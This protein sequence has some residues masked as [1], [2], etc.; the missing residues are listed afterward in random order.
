MKSIIHVLIIAVFLIPSLAIS[1]GNPKDPV[2]AKA[3]NVQ[4]TQYELNREINKVLPFSVNFHGG[5]SEEKKQEIH[6][7]ALNTVI[8]RALK[9]QYALDNEISAPSSLVEK[10]VSE[11]ASK[12]RSP[13]E[14][15]AGL[16]GEG[17]SGFRASV[18]RELLAK[19]AENIVVE[20]KIQVSEEDV[21]NYF[22]E[23]KH[24]YVRPRQYQASHILV[25]V[26]PSSNKEE[27]AELKKKAQDLLARAKSGE[28]F[29]NLAYYNSDDRSKYVGGDLGL[30]HEGQT[31]SEFDAALK[32]MEVGEISDLVKTMYGYHIIKM[33]KINES[34][35]LK[36]DE[37]HDKIKA[38]LEKEQ[39]DKLYDEWIAGLRE[40]YPV[41]K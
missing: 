35:Q 11:Y 37:M 33:V 5:I 32:E 34:R 17:L 21:K 22:E 13:Q 1:A 7:D 26:D 2:I 39:R 9:V 15:E 31:V 41:V 29:Y 8:E 24:R 19:E 30:F 4:I 28:D 27:K 18:Y 23:N 10:K 6:D 38:Q 20:N 3:G 14:F 12:F 40:K 25:K 16:G 36:Y